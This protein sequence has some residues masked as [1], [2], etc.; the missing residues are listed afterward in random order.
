ME[1]RLVIGCYSVQAEIGVAHRRQP[2][3]F[4]AV[5]EVGVVVAYLSGR[6]R[7]SGAKVEEVAELVETV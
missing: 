4:Y 3:D 2:E 5:I 7:G 1:D 6:Q